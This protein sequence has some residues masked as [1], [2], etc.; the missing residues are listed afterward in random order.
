LGKLGISSERVGDDIYALA[1]ASSH[2]SV[3]ITNFERKQ[4]T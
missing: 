1:V 4:T 3:T 2:L